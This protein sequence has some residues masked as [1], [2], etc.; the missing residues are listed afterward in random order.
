MTLATPG[1][2]TGLGA[3]TSTPG[4]SLF[5]NTGATTTPSAGGIFG[6]TATPAPTTGG[7]FGGGTGTAGGFGT[8]PLGGTTGG[9]G[10]STFGAA[11]PATG[12]L[13]GKLNL[14]FVVPNRMM[15]FVSPIVGGLFGTTPAQAPAST[16]GFSFGQTP[17]QPAGG[18]GIFGNAGTSI[19]GKGFG[20]TP[21]TFGATTTSGF[22]GGSNMLTSSL[23]GV[24]SQQQQATGPSLQASIDRNPY[25]NNPLF[26]ASAPTKLSKPS[27]T[28]EPQLF[29][30]P[31]GEKKQPILPHFKVTPRSANKMKLRGFSPSTLGDFA[32]STQSPKVGASKDGGLPKGVLNMLKADQNDPLSRDFPEAF[33]PRVK[34]LVITNEP[35]G[36]GGPSGGLTSAAAQ[37][38]ASSKIG[39]FAPSTTAKSVRFVDE[40]DA[41]VPV[42]DVT[43]DYDASNRS[44]AGKAPASIFGTPKSVGGA[45]DA[46]A[47][48]T[49]LSVSNLQNASI[50]ASPVGAST[51]SGSAPSSASKT[52]GASKSSG[53]SINRSPSRVPE[54]VTEPSMEEIMDMSEAELSRLENFT[55]ILP[56]VGKIRFLEPVNLLQASPTGTVEGISR[57]PGTVIILRHKMVEVYPDETEKDPV[58]MGVNVPAE[59]HLERCWAVDKA[60]GKV[61]EDDSDPRFERHF[62]K[63]SSVPG[64]KIIGFNKKTGC[65][66]FRI[67]SF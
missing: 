10:M 51:A 9:F 6:N 15:P 17:A 33:K 52:N 30:T 54:Y 5:G 31:G 38:P 45:G 63:L 57:I 23:F 59:V 56:G 16:G 41:G 26:D 60:T 58:G 66:K 43:G 24:G 20:A 2:G 8:T 35:S 39:G 48:G 7:L 25:G 67:E 22:G 65:W 12:R 18:G 46:S 28:S 21:S 14:N 4:T 61:I 49:P 29:A 27:I 36:V 37:T 50:N 47:S 11:K 42:V 3:G 55:V 19:G 53:S 40:N 44:P 32:S 64:T 13:N 34:K 62:K 1:F